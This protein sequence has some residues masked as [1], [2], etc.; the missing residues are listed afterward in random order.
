MADNDNALPSSRYA[1]SS[2]TNASNNDSS[3]TTHRCNNFNNYVVKEGRSHQSSIICFLHLLRSMSSSLF[4]FACQTVFFYN[5]SPSF[6]WSTSSPGT[7]HFILHLFPH[8]IID[9]FLQH[10]P[11][12]HKLFCCS[13]EIMW[14]NL[15]LFFN[16][17]L[18]TLSCS[19][20]PHIHLT[21][22]ISAHWIATSFSFLTGQVSLPCNILLRKQLLYN[23]PLTI[24]DISLLVSNGTNCLNLFHRIW[25]IVSTAASASPS[26]LNMSPNNKTYL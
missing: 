2:H 8:P 5:L 22:L 7:L 4:N 18:G 20:T 23:L 25:T 26:T 19:I 11:Y 21:I 17:L 9:F 6:L 13:T 1:A 15:S 3:P 10:M 16:P 24:N 12:H 14:S